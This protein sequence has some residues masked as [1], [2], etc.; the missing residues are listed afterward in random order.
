[1]GSGGW[2]K[3][4]RAADLAQLWGTLPDWLRG[5]AAMARRE[6]SRRR[7]LV[8]LQCLAFRV[9]GRICGAPCRVRHWR[10]SR[11]HLHI[12]TPEQSDRDL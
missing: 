4:G 6:L 1:M 5:L 9:A 10:S 8:T 12:S 2:T 7:Y 3:L 11:N